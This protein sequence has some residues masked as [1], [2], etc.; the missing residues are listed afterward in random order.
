[1]QLH[2]ASFPAILDARSHVSPTP[3]SH[4]GR[5]AGM[6][7]CTSAAW[8]LAL[9]RCLEIL[10]IATSSIGRFTISKCMHDAPAFASKHS[11]CKRY[12]ACP[13]SSALMTEDPAMWWPRQS[14]THSICASRQDCAACA[15]SISGGVVHLF[16]ATCAEST[17]TIA[18]R[19]C[20]THPSDAVVLRIRSRGGPASCQCRWKTLYVRPAGRVVMLQTCALDM[21]TLR[22]APQQ[23]DHGQG[24]LGGRVAGVVGCECGRLQGERFAGGYGPFVIMAAASLR[25][26]A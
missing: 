15:F 18:A 26:H 8:I 24:C 6:C 3:Q 17:V 13:P 5:R 10:C 9:E 7:A 21:Q 23:P 11:D 4:T 25:A 12:K 2:L 22:L 20:R 16:A 19:R 14:F 1:M